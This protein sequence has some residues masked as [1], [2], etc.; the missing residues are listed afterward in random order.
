MILESLISLTGALG[1]TCVIAIK[2]FARAR[3]GGCVN[4]F[5]GRKSLSVVPLGPENEYVDDKGS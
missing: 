3:V 5:R 4:F 2:E 1:G